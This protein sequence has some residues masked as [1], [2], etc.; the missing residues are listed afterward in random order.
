MPSW[1]APVVE[2]Q[3]EACRAALDRAQALAERFRLDTPDLPF[4]AL[5]FALQDLMEPLDAFEAAAVRFRRLRR[6]RR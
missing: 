5:M 2:E 4:D 6:V 1:R 3:W